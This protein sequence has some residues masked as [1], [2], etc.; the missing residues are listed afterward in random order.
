MKK[1]IENERRTEHGSAG[2]KHEERKKRGR[3]SEPSHG[4]TEKRSEG[5]EPRPS[6]LFIANLFVFL[7]LLLQR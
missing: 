4:M 3:P 1:E 5:N 2:Y 6:N 7:F